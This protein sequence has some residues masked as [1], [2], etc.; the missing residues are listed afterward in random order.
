LN[1]DLLRRWKLLSS[2]DVTPGSDLEQEL[3]Q[4]EV[5]LLTVSTSPNPAGGHYRLRFSDQASVDVFPARKQI[6]EAQAAPDVSQDTR[7]HFLADQVLPR[8]LAHE[9]RLVV[10]AAAVKIGRRAILI[11]GESG[12][13]KSTLS[14]SFAEA[15]FDLLGDDA[16]V[17]SRRD[18]RPLVKAV[19]PSLRLFPDSIDALYA[20]APDAAAVAHYSPKRRIPLSVATDSG[21]SELASI[22]VIASP[23]EGSS[24]TIQPL[25]VAESCIAMITNSFALDPT[26]LKLA[27]AK[28]DEA[29]ACARLLP[30][31]AISYPREYARLPDVR[32]AIRERLEQVAAKSDSK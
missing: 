22:F 18:G 29:S 16:M 2:S 24:V 9:G 20:E 3:W 13:G 8:L 26:D 19:Y 28:L 7:D 4:D 30:A 6:Q 32:A 5:G 11:V 1:S 14:A 15:G 31:F 10:H 21:E 23:A 17:V 25:S 12:Q 27:Q